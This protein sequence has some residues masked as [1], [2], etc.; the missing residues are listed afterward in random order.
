[1]DMLVQAELADSIMADALHD[2]FQATQHLLILI[3]I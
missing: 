2:K 1:M 3:I